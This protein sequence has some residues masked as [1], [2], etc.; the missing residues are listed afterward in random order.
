MSERKNIHHEEH[1]GQDL[2]D[3]QKR[4]N[5]QHEE[6]EKES[7]ESVLSFESDGTDIED[8]H[9][10]NVTNNLTRRERDATFKSVVR[11]LTASR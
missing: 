3:E 11:N 9:C 8:S 6:E 5:Q 7:E 10:E 4:A 2:V 1:N